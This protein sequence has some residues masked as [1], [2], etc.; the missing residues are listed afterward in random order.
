MKSQDTLSQSQL[1]NQC[2][3]GMAASIVHDVIDGSC[4]F[5]NKSAR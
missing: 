5:N 2:L 1:R 4:I 3:N